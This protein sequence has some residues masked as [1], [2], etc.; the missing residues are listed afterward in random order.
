M[1]D[2]FWAI[3]AVTLKANTYVK[4]A[5]GK[6]SEMDKCWNTVFAYTPIHIVANN[7]AYINLGMLLSLLITVV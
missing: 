2:I 5:K 6:K 7:N 3:G 4:L 1:Y